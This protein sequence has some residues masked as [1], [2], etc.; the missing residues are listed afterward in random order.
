MMNADSRNFP[1]AFDFELP[2]TS[3]W[4]KPACNRIVEV[5]DSWADVE[6][7]PKIIIKLDLTDLKVVMKYRWN[8]KRGRAQGI[9]IVNGSEING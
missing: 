5:F 6:I 2:I 8:P 1:N 7:C 9:L 4:H 3:K